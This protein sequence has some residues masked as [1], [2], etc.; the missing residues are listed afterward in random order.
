MRDT[1]AQSPPRDA[2]LT[3]K[4][5]LQR[6]PQAPA[7][8]SRSPVCTGDITR[9]PFHILT[10]LAIALDDDRDEETTIA[11]M[12]TPTWRFAPRRRLFDEVEEVEMSSNSSAGSDIQSYDDDQHISSDRRSNGSRKIYAHRVVRSQPRG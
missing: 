6:P 3:L 8:R 11:E 7:R 9:I 5:I 10:P 12:I 1:R 2:I 4:D